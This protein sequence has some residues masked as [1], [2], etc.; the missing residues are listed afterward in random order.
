MTLTSCLLLRRRSVISESSDSRQKKRGA[1]GILNTSDDEF[2]IEFPV[3]DEV[4]DDGVD[5]ID[6]DGVDGNELSS[7]DSESAISSS[8]GLAL[9]GVRRIRE[10]SCSQDMVVI[11]PLR[12][13]Y[14]TICTIQIHPPYQHPPSRLECRS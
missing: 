10:I 6:M 8:R 9:P 7:T 14:A 1:A 13:I 3:S 2:E 11:P 12:R 5:G 4:D